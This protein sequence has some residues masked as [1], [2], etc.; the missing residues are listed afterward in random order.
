MGENEKA[1]E[2][3]LRDLDFRVATEV[4]W[5]KLAGTKSLRTKIWAANPDN[6]PTVYVSLGVD[7]VKGSVLAYKTVN[8]PPTVWQPSRDIVQAMQVVDELLTNP[9]F[10]NTES[11]EPLIALNARVSCGWVCEI[12]G[13]NIWVG[14][15]GDTPTEAICKA[16]LAFVGRLKLI[17][18]GEGRGIITFS[19]GFTANQR[20]ELEMLLPKLSFDKEWRCYTNERGYFSC[21]GG[22]FI[23]A[24]S[25]EVLIQRVN[26]MLEKKENKTETE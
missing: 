4:M 22:Y 12:R 5:W 16:A 15:Y 1:K 23:N 14:E 10:C 18:S 7:F 25:F 2:Q 9:K 3:E 26:L 6:F 21:G 20:K 24:R 19:E 17:A 8:T 11:R 13:F